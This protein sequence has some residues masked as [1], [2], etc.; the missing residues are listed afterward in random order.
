MMHKK[1]IKSI[2][3]YNDNINTG[4]KPLDRQNNYSNLI[5]IHLNTAAVDLKNE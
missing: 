2:Y 5:N 3:N 4:N 1:K